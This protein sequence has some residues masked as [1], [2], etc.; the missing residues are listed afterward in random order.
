MV[1]NKKVK[2][3]RFKSIPEI[4]ETLDGRNECA[5]TGIYLADWVRDYIYNNPV[6]L[7][8]ENV[9]DFG[10]YYSLRTYFGLIY[11][12]KQWIK[13]IN[14]RYHKFTE[15]YIKFDSFMKDENNGENTTN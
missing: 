3:M 10:N 11:L 7:M 15:L 2:E 13:E 8:D 6:V 4:Y 12:S 1:E 9:E 14:E 5:T